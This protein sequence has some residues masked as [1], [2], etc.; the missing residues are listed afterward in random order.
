VRRSP[1]RETYVSFFASSFDDEHK[2]LVDFFEWA[3]SLGDAVFY[4]WHNYE[5]THLR[6]MIDHYGLE[7]ELVTP[8]M[9][10]LVDLSPIT[11]RAFAF[12]CYGEGLKDIARSIGFSWRQEDVSAM[13]SVALFLNYVGSGGADQT[14]RQKILDYNEDDCMATMHVY[15]WLVSQ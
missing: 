4:H 12:P 6:K 14:A 2:N 11:V 3:G 7:Q 9:D 5:R 1:G 8:V 13:V 10:H 15:D